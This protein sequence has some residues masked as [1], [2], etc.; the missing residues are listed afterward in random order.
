MGGFGG[1]VVSMFEY[2]FEDM[3][4]FTFSIL[5]VLSFT[6]LGSTYHFLKRFTW[7]TILKLSLTCVVHIGKY[8]NFYEW[9]V[10]SH[11]KLSGLDADNL[12]NHG[13]EIRN[14]AFKATITFTKVTYC[15]K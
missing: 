15:S 7:T 11:F 3:L 2:M 10:P 4:G 1:T 12:V 8:F 9:T 14:K 6:D 5:T 13:K